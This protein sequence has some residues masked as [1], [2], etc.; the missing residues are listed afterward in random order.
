MSGFPDDVKLSA[1]DWPIECTGPHPGDLKIVLPQGFELAAPAIIRPYGG[2][3][4]DDDYGFDKASAHPFVN[5]PLTGSAGGTLYFDD[6]TPMAELSTALSIMSVHQTNDYITCADTSCDGREM[7]H[8]PGQAQALVEQAQLIG[9]IRLDEQHQIAVREL[10]I[11]SADLTASSQPLLG[12]RWARSAYSSRRG[13]CAR[14]NRQDR[15]EALLAC[16]R[17]VKRKLGSSDR[18]R[19]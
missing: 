7:N 14:A 1:N 12:I 9:P 11:V 15:I 3:P 19:S 2:A 8:S 4:Q 5:A 10:L 16:P 17:R 13:S 6:N 18:S